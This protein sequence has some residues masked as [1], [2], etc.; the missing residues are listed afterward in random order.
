MYISYYYEPTLLVLV[1]GVSY[2]Y[3]QSSVVC[4]CQSVY[5]FVM[6]LSHTKTAD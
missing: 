5:L 3:K 2:C 6:T 1:P 4:L